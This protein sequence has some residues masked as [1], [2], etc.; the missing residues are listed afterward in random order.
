MDWTREQI[1]DWVASFEPI[2][3]EREKK[4]ITSNESVI[5]KEPV[6]ENEKILTEKEELCEVM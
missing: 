4:Q 2:E 5:L 1:A 3:S 6:Y